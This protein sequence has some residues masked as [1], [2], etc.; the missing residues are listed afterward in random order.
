MK[1][2]LIFLCCLFALSVNAQVTNTAT[3]D[4][5]SFHGKGNVTIEGYLDI[6]YAYDFNKPPSGNRGYFVSMARHN[7]MN[8]NLAYIDVRYSQQRTRARFVPGFGTYVNSNYANEPGTLVNLIEASAGVKIW[9]EKNIWL[10]AGVFGSPYTNE[11]AISK[12]HLAY[13]RS[14]APEYVPY[15]LAGLKLTIP[16][17]DRLNMYLYALNGWQQIQDLNKSKSIGTQLEYRPS[18]NWLVNWSNYVGNEQSVFTPTYRYRYFTDLYFIYSKAPW[19]ATGSVYAGLQKRN[20]LSDAAWWQAN[21]IGRYNISPKV[22]V[23]GRFEY[24]RD[25]KE[26]MIQSITSVNGFTSFSSSL[27]LNVKVIENVVFRAEARTFLSERNVYERD[28]IEV[29]NNNLV[30]TNITFWF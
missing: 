18:T 23:T 8:V 7:E 22:S 20:N 30:T 15:Y 5:T 13:T 27:G 21:I 14:F 29:R 1:V 24:F 4:T 10:D 19:S 9:K 11:S 25:E 2:S 6:Y 26:A 12:D 17:G 28:G 16:F 3:I